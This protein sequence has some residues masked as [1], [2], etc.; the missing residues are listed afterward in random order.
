[1]TLIAGDEFDAGRFYFENL[2]AVNVP[3]RHAAAGCRSL[4][5][6]KTMPAAA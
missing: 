4:V 1:V 5:L 3:V 6:T 2:V